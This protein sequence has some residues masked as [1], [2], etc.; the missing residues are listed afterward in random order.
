MLRGDIDIIFSRV[1]GKSKGGAGL[2]LAQ[3]CNAM[4]LLARKRFAVMLENQELQ[5]SQ[6]LDELCQLLLEPFALDAGLLA[7]PAPSSRVEY[8]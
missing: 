4:E 5:R 2:S 8:G 1:R 7:A 6:A 3:F